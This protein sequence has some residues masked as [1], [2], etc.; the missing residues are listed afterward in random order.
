VDFNVS[1]NRSTPGR[2]ALKRPR[3][4]NHEFP[5]QRNIPRRK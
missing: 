4:D 2:F 1:Q 5:G 3:S